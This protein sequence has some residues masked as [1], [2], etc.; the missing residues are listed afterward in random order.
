[1]S[2]I[3]R[4]N[5]LLI[6][7]D[8]QLE[9]FRS[10]FVKY[11][12]SREE[13]SI[14]DGFMGIHWHNFLYDLRATRLKRTHSKWY[15]KKYKDQ[16]GRTNEK[17]LMEI[18]QFQSVIR[19]DTKRLRDWLNR[20]PIEKY[21]FSKKREMVECKKMTLSYF[22]SINRRMDW[23]DKTEKNGKLKDP[24]LIDL[25]TPFLAFYC[26]D[27]RFTS[28][29]VLKHVVSNYRLSWHSFAKNV[30]LHPLAMEYVNIIQ[31][32]SPYFDTKDKLV[33]FDAHIRC[34]GQYICDVQLPL[35]S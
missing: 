35:P 17:E 3:I 13:D 31:Q 24:N 8:K 7:G 26:T 20:Y 4:H 10:S 33:K 12:C 16:F 23:L 32:E 1:L 9:K 34:L 19:S 2:K 21:S 28:L 5:M 27:R 14:P 11:T 25:I 18:Q 6:F 29:E 22:V 15:G 30:V